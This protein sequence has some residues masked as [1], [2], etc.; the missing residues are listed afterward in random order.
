VAPRTRAFRLRALAALPALLALLGGSC[1]RDGR[2]PVFP[3]SGQVLYEGKATQGALVIFHPLNDPDPRAPRPV[4]RVGQDGRFS[5][6]TYAAGDGA[7]AGEYAVT[8][9]WVQEVDNQNAPRE[10]QKE[11]RNLLPDRYSKPAT[12]G[13][14]V[15][16]KAGRNDLPPFRLTRE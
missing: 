7:P 13:L 3:V 2:R 4:A 16:V 14:R 5:P 11:P 6:T 8:V 9:A 1:A 12:S 10:E 15:Q